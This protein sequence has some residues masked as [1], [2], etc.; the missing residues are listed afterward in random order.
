M[1][2]GA[3]NFDIADLVAERGV[4]EGDDHLRDER[5]QHRRD[6]LGEQHLEHGLLVA[7][8]QR[9]S[10][11]GLALGQRADA[12]AQNLGDD[13]AVVERE[14]ED[15]GAE[16]EVLGRHEV[17]NREELVGENHEQQHGD[18]AEELHD[19]AA[20]P[21]DGAVLAQAS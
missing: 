8:S 19:N 16:G 6:G 10:C 2:T 3:D 13:G 4:L 9:L 17:V 15:N 12:G 21:A 20:H 11:L 5:R 18:G 1:D 14:R 7:Q